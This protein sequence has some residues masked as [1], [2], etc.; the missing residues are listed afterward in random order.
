MVST[1]IGLL[2]IQSWWEIPCISHFCSLFS[3]AFDLPDID[4]EDLESALLSDGT[5]EDQIALVPELIVRLLKGC[6]ALKSVAKEITHSNYQMFL[7]RFLRQQCPIHNTENHFDT[8]IDFQSLPVRK[9]LQIL[10]DLCHFRLDSCD[11]Q[12]ILSN[13]EADSLRVEPLGYDSKNSGYWYFY[14]TRLYREDK[15]TSSVNSHSGG[16]GG[17]GGGSGGNK[18]ATAVVNGSR[19]SGENSDGAVWQV[20]CFTEEDWQNLASKFKSSTNAKERELYQILDENFLPKL[21]QLFRERERLRRRKLLQVRNS[22][23]LR[24]IVELKARQEQERLLRERQ[25]YPFEPPTNL[26]SQQL[27]AQ[28]R[29]RRRLARELANNSST[30]TTRDSHN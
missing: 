29:A 7:R 26:K 19:G 25:R 8:D 16:G 14:G 2:D 22:T 20:I 5:D 17:G 3:S 30:N 24:N 10:H 15:S 21:P 23:R 13:L 28:S 11:V 1:F 6:D 18:S 27:S 12:V 9:R 4:I